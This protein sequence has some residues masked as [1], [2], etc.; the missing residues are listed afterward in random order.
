MYLKSGLGF[1]LST[2]KDLFNVCKHL[3]GNNLWGGKNIH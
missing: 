1:L 2:Y 3:S